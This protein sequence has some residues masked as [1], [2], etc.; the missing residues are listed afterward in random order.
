MPGL[1]ASP[2]IFERI[3]LPEDQFETILLEWMLP[4]DGE[5]LREYAVR[6]AKSITHENPVL[7]GVSF[8]GIVVQEIAR[9]IPVRKT[10]I[11][12]SAK[13]NA[14]YPRRFK[15][16]KKT[17]AYKLLPLKLL[18]KVENLAKYSFGEKINERLKLY[19]KY[20]SI[21]DVKYLAWAIEQVMLWDRCEPDPN[22]IHIHGEADEVFP[23]KYINGYIPVKDGTHIMIVNRFRWINEN[24]PKIILD[25]LK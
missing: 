6:I 13:C 3:K 16:A 21:R 1:A 5:S 11:I 15:L 22:V 4:L 25:A 8:G 20:L 23:A 2:L 19:E 10:I 7:V 24:L 9:V 12:S 14:E 18:L 17:G